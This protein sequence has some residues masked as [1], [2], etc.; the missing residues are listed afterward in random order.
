MIFVCDNKVDYICIHADSMVFGWVDPAPCSLSPT[1]LRR[2]ALYIYI[3]I[4]IYM[5]LSVY[6][7]FNLP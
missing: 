2:Y 7:L 6:L 4:Y 3:Y 5:D 1:T